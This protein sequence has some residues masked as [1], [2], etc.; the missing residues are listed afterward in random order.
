M[1][2]PSAV[3]TRFLIRSK[4]SHKGDYGRVYI[5]A[6]SKGMSGAA[7]LA[8]IAALRSGAG[9]VTLGIPDAIYPIVARRDPE[10]MVQ[11]FPSTSSGTFDFRAFKNIF[12]RLQNQD[13]LAMGPGLSRNQSTVKL[14]QKIIIHAK[15]PTVLDADA[16]NALEGY[17]HLLLETA[18]PLVLTPH[19]VEFKRV[20]GFD[21][22]ENHMQRKKSAV[23][24]AEKYGVFIV[25]KGHRTVVASPDGRSFVNTTGNPGM[26]T[27][28]SGDVLTGII[29]G[30][31]G[32]GKNRFQ[33]ICSA[34]WI[35]GL[36]GDDAARKKGQTSLIARD[37]LEFLPQAFIQAEKAQK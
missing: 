33:T 31:L 20:F 30:L 27:A 5:L 35:H 17:A 4:K 1:K 2:L 24:M 25:L 23:D 19:A 34:V 7:S 36:A 16:L 12:T 21:P 10:V 28:G 3:S 22:G 29:A 9:L 32:Y 18:A 14:I 37:I 11:P 15:I 13:V 8:A 26:A 6:G